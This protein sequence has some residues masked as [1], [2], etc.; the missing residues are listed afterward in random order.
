VARRGTAAGMAF[1]AVARSILPRSVSFPAVEGRLRFLIS[2]PE[3][4]RRVGATV[5]R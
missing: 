5:T 1:D 3:R 4:P 2:S